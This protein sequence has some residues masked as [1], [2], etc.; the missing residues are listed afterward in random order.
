M[1]QIDRRL[2]E[3]AQIGAAHLVDEQ[4]NEDG[5]GEDENHLHGRDDQRV[6]E[7]LKKGRRVEQC[8]EVFEAHE[9]V[10]AENPEILE[11]ELGLVD[12]E[13]VEHQKIDDARSHHS[14]VGPPGPELEAQRSS[15]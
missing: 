15:P 5:H 1:G 7:N 9:Q 10:V 11:G 4:R 13:I 6:G 3:T 2:N 12:G 8:V 14:V